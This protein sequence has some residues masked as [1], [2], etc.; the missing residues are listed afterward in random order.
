MSEKGSDTH[1]ETQS[2]EKASVEDSGLITPA[3]VDAEL[4]YY[5]GEE[6]LPPPPELT[7]E[8][9]RALWRKIDM[10]LMPILT[11]MY[12]CSF[13]DRGNIGEWGRSWGVDGAEESVGNAKLQGLTTQLNLTGNKYN[14]ALVRGFDFFMFTHA[15]ISI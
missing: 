9:E 8:Q 2:A 4:A 1:A 3:K 13:L 5:G 6:T 7:A 14:I 11:L 12:L 10:R 15:L